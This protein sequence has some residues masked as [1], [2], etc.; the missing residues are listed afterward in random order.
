MTYLKEFIDTVHQS[1]HDGRYFSCSYF[2][3]T[4]GNNATIRLLVQSGV[5]PMHTIIKG[6]MGGDALGRLYENPVFSNA[7]TS[8]IVSNH[9]RTSE[10]ECDAVITHTP[11]LSSSGS[12]INGTSFIPGGTGVFSVGSTVEGFKSEIIFSPNTD[13]LLEITNTAGG[14]QPGSIH[15]EFY[16]V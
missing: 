2:N 7:G 14:N 12:Q 4:I 9:N 15:I 11:T 1:V 5:H 3:N 10:R 8:L 13:Y 6:A 16:E